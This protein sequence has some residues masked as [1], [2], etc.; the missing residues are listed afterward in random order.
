VELFR[1]HTPFFIPKRFWYYEDDEEEEESSEELEEDASEDDDD[2]V[3]GTELLELAG[4]SEVELPA[5]SSDIPQLKPPDWIVYTSQ[6]SSELS[7]VSQKIKLSIFP[8]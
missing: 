1:F 8:L 3:G 4:P 5:A 2:P 6:I 7:S